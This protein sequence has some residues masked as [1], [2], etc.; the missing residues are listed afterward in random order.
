[1]SNSRPLPLHV[2]KALLGRVLVF[3]L[4]DLHHVQLEAAG[5]GL[6]WT[7]VRQLVDNSTA[8]QLEYR[9]SGSLADY[10]HQLSEEIRSSMMPLPDKGAERVCI[11]L[12]D[13]IDRVLAAAGSAQDDLLGVAFA[14]AVRATDE[15]Y[16]AHELDFPPDMLERIEVSFDHQ[17]SSIG[18]ELPIHLLA[19]TYLEDRAQ[20]PSARVSVVVNAR[21]M[22]EKTAFSLPYVFLHECICHVFQGPWQ[23]GRVQADANSRF[24]EG[25]MDF[26]SYSVHKVLDRPWRTDTAQPDLMVTPRA[27]ARQEA[28]ETVHRARYAQN[29]NDRAWAHRAMGVQAA[30]NMLALLAKIPEAR[31]DALKP[32]MRLSLQLNA[33]SFNNQQRDL[34]VAGIYS[35]TLSRPHPALV[36][37]LRKYLT[38]DELSPLVEEVFKLFT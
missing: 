12:L 16:R 1:V 24:A 18:S 23:P 38:S 32:F 31:S 6:L 21:L 27:A 20:G 13:E 14:D 22:D 35:A 9:P 8:R 5:Y 33:S 29:Q 3:Q 11:P 36:P 2:Q 4:L 28:A 30:H 19:T 37:P 26:V 17:F 7:A 10:L 34:F 25:W 15:R